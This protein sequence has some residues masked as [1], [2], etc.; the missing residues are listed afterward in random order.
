[1]QAHAEVDSYCSYDDVKFGFSGD[2]DLDIPPFVHAAEFAS[3]ESNTCS[4]SFGLFSDIS[5]RDLIRY[6]EAADQISLPYFDWQGALRMPT[7]GELAKAVEVLTYRYDLNSPELVILAMDLATALENL[8]RDAEAEF[9]RRRVLRCL[10]KRYGK[11]SANASY[12]ASQLAINLYKQK[13][14][15]EA[16]KLLR[17]ALPAFRNDFLATSFQ[18]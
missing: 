3:S 13:K 4:N 10:T 14:T 8:H 9:Y 6:R 17:E 5:G 1:M 12:A 11:Q 15:G 18:R 7:P 2:A 16:S